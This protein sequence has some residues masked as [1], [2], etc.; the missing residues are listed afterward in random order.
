MKLLS[1][2]ITAF[3]GVSERAL[4]FRDGV[5][6]LL[7]RNGAGK[8]TLAAFIKVMLYGLEKSGNGISDNELTLYAPWQGGRFGGSLTLE[9]RGQRY[10]IERHYER[11][12]KIKTQMDLRVVNETTGLETDVLGEEPG[13]T[14]LGVDGPSFLRTA[15]LSSRGITA[16]K[17]ADISARLGGLEGEADDMASVETAIKLL[18]S[19]RSEVRTQNKQKNGQKLLDIA[20]RELHAIEGDL[21]AARAASAALP[22]AEAALSTLGTQLAALDADMTALRAAKTESDRHRGEREATERRLAELESERT[23]AGDELNT[24]SS[25]FPE[26]VPSEEILS[27]LSRDAVTFTRV[28]EELRAESGASEERFPTAEETSALRA[29]IRERQEIRTRPFVF[30]DPE[31]GKAAP[32]RRARTPIV[33]LAASG[34][35]AAVALALLF[36]SPTVGAVLLALAIA[37]GGAGLVLLMRDRSR[38][39]DLEAVAEI[40]WA[41]RSRAALA[42]AIRSADEEAARLLDVFGLAADADE[43]ALDRL[44]ARAA[45][46]KA[47][48]ERI[49]RLT[50]TRREAGERLEQGLRGY[51]GLPLTPDF[52]VRVRA[53]G[54]LTRK[55][56]VA[57]ATLT[58]LESEIARLTVAHKATSPEDG[59]STEQ[60]ASILTECESRRHSLAEKQTSAREALERTR[61]VA[62]TLPSL[63]DAE[64]RITAEIAEHR[65]RILT[66]DRTVEFLES[67]RAAYEEAYLGG[68]RR[69]IGKYAALLFGEGA[70]VRVDLDLNLSFLAGGEEHSVLYESTGRRAIADICLR[71]ALLDALYPDDPPPLLLDDPFVALDEENLATALSLLKALGR[72]RRILYLTCHPSRSTK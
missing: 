37:A 42:A 15:Y 5:T 59:P 35:L 43:A 13:R 9:H 27:A 41:E 68:I 32:P 36:L 56:A 45:E 7:D 54:E 25:H 3:G 51:R 34:A 58:R 60:L 4:T 30:Q 28:G 70:E 55:R 29:A 46:A 57:A 17:T 44:A 23:A 64:A 14:L 38:R 21:A 69:H 50:E 62:D 65:A 22:E 48:A 33:L 67:A 63:L 39:Q 72:E 52:A 12:G 11:L 18:K 49:E 24:L 40:R 1:L 66:L 10:R 31:G 8:S 2:Y 47:K 26:G 20:E 16:A 61:A 6:E 71:L 19:K 53:L